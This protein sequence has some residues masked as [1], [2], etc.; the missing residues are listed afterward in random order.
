M[1]FFLFNF[2]VWFENSEV[3]GCLKVFIV[4]VLFFVKFVFEFYI[5]WE[6]EVDDGY[7]ISYYEVFD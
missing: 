6:Q 1:G 2:L 7:Y 5:V 4:L 3:K